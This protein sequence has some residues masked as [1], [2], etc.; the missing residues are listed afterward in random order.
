MESGY[1]LFVGIDWANESHQVCVLDAAGTTLTEFRV[2]HSSAGM[3]MLA[4]R[5][6]A[7]SGDASRVVCAIE[8]NRGAL[9]E[10]LVERGFAVVSVNPKQLDRFRDRHTA[11]GAKDDRRDAYVLADALRT[12]FDRMRIVRADDPL[13]IQLRESSRLHEELQGDL[14]R[15]ANR[16]REQL[17][18]YFPQLLQLSGSADEPWVWSLLMLAPTPHRARRLKKAQLSKLLREHRIRRITATELHA[19]LAQPPLRLAPGSVEAASEHARS[20]VKRLRLTHEEL[21]DNDK[22]LRE[23]FKKLSEP[24]DAHE[25]NGEHRDA[26]ILLSMPGLGELN[27]AAMLSEASQALRERDYHGLRALGGLAPVTKQSGR[28]RVVIMR[29]A[30]NKRLRNALYT[31]AMCSLSNDEACRRFYHQCRTR[32]IPHAHALR[33]LGDRLLRILIA[34]LRDG[35]LYDPARVQ[36]A[37]AA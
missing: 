28:R 23:L 8:L 19:A 29:R 12:D 27:G 13:I 33:S 14:R 1:D 5:L 22:H 21:R 11:A 25:E 36:P 30:C 20:L 4:S 7:H 15:L 18:R 6:L 16:L 37:H 31:W 10:G 3:S 2:E 24:D 26:T 35:T 34:M 32:G 9:V 17:H